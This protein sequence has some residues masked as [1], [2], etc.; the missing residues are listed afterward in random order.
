MNL[1]SPECL[2]HTHLNPSCSFVGWGGMGLI[3]NYFLAHTHL[4]PSFVLNIKQIVY[5]VHGQ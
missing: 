1:N 2:A 4:N 3:I 5:G